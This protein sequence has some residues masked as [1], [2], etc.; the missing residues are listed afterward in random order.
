M[1]I[2]HLTWGLGNGGAENLLVDLANHQSASHSV[3]ILLVNADESDH[4]VRRIAATVSVVRFGRLKGASRLSAVFAIRSLI[5]RLGVDVV[6]CHSQTLAPFVFGLNVPSVLTVHNSYGTSAVC[7]LGFST[8]VAISQNVKRTIRLIAPRKVEVIMNGFD[9]ALIP[10][11]AGDPQRKSGVVRIVQV[12]RLDIRAKGQDEVLRS[13]AQLLVQFSQR[14]CCLDF[15]GE[16]PS[17][18]E[19]KQLTSVLGLGTRVRFLGQLPREEVLRRLGEY[20]FLVHPA[21]HEGFGLVVAE[22]MSVGV[23]PIV[24]ANTGAAEVL[25]P[26][27]WGYIFSD[28]RDLTNK[29][30]AALAGCESGEYARLSSGARRHAMAQFSVSDCSESYERL[31]LEVA[32]SGSR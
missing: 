24:R 1:N 25:G 12:G 21:K 31:Y 27:K 18:Q 29:L 22:A 16:G 28:G 30:V 9:Q 10:P 8:I 6:H 2:I 15:F 3:R 17:L 26:G 5:N 23:V 32:K 19:L 14:E 11:Q 7:G 13:F 4:V 20:R